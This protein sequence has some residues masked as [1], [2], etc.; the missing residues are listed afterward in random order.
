[1]PIYYQKAIEAALH[2]IRVDWLSETSR[3]HFVETAAELPLVRAAVKW[4][5]PLTKRT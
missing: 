5:M 4:A 1:M 2:P 3:P